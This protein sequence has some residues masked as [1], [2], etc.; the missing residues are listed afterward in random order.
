MSATS[1][2]LRTGVDPTVQAGT[3]IWWRPT[4][5]LS[6]AGSP[7]SKSDHLLEIDLQ[8]IKGLALAVSPREAWDIAHQEPRLRAALNY[9]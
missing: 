3:E 1:D 8:L 9:C 6:R 4:K 5:S 2:G 7:S